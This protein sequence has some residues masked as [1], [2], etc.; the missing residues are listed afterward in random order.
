MIIRAMTPDDGDRVV[1]IYGRAIT[2]GHA[3]FQENPG[4]WAD[5]ILA[6][7]PNAGWLR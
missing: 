5:W 1:D 2:S 3:T 4:S 6:I 7:C